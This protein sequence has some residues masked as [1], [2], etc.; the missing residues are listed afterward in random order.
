MTAEGTLASGECPALVN[1]WALDSLA[2]KLLLAQDYLN[3]PAQSRMMEAFQ[4]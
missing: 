3:R 2:M 1:T 4:G